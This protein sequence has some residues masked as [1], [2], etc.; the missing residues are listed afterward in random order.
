MIRDDKRLIKLLHTHAE[1]TRLEYT[2]VRCQ[3]KYK[4]LILMIMQM[5]TKHNII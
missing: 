4:L 1:Q 3:V 2:E 5:K